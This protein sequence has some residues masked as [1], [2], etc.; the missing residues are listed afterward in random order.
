MESTDL[1]PPFHCVPGVGFA[2]RKMGNLAKPTLEIT[3]NGDDWKLK[4]ISTFK[5]TEID[6]KV[7]QEFDEKTA[8]GRDVKVGMASLS[9]VGPHSG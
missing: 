5:T 2:T 6:F 1:P 8:D 4:T 3:Q 9:A 7:G